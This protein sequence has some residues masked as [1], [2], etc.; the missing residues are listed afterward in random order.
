MLFLEHSRE[1]GKADDRVHAREFLSILFETELINR[2]LPFLNFRRD[3]CEREQA[4][5]LRDEFAA[6][7]V[8]PVNV[9]AA[10]EGERAVE[11]GQARLA[12]AVD[13]DL[14][15]VA[16][17][18]AGSGDDLPVAAEQ[19]GEPDR[20]QHPADGPA[21][22]PEA[23]PGALQPEG[24]EGRVEVLHEDRRPRGEEHPDEQ[25]EPAAAVRAEEQLQLQ[26]A[27]DHAEEQADPDAR[28]ARPERQREQEPLQDAQAPRDPREPQPVRPE[29]LNRKRTVLRSDH[30]RVLGQQSHPAAGPPE[31]GHAQHLLPARVLH[32]APEHVTSEEKSKGVGEDRRAVVSRAK[33]FER[34]GVLLQSA[35]EAE[36]GGD[37]PYH[38]LLPFDPCVDSPFGLCGFAPSI[39]FCPRN[40]ILLKM[41]FYGIK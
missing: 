41:S 3:H 17:E 13:S 34:E 32:E 11:S 19:P 9:E 35:L 39:C 1:V 26:P 10:P 40:R 25:Q 20:V 24:R 5:D 12:A 21:A 38:L 14:F 7:A 29:E 15:A 4:G 6:G 27:A 16:A 31:G 23:D 18:E 30:R 8:V 37:F 36:Q 22:H 2:P 33:W 28:Q